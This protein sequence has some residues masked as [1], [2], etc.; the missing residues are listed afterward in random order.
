MQPASNQAGDDNENSS[1][2]E[3]PNDGAERLREWLLG[4]L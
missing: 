4:G 3:S 1:E 2:D